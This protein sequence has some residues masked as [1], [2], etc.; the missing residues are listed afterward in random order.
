METINLTEA[1]E[2]FAE[3]VTRVASGER[4]IIQHQDQPVA[5]L[6][7]AAELGHL[8]RLTQSTQ[9]LASALG[10]DARLLKKIESR[11]IHPAMAAFG[12]WRGESEFGDLERRIYANRLHQSSRSEV[13]W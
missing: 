3:L 2:H 8:E 1:Q 12:L 7:S 10:Q 13:K 6:I 9:K 4:I 11:D 5:A